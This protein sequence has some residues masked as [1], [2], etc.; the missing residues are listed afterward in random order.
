MTRHNNIVV[1][2]GTACGPKAAARARRCDPAARITIIEQ[3][4]N[5]SQATCGLP[6]Y[7]SGVIESRDDMV[8]RKP[9]YFRTVM[10]M[11]VLISTKATAVFPEAHKVQ[12]IDLKKDQTSDI[13]YDKLVL[14]TGAFPDIPKVEGASLNGIFT[15]SKIRDAL[16]IQ[17]LIAR[18]KIERV[19]V[20]GAGLIGLEMAEAF[21]SMG[22]KVTVIE[23][24]GWVLPKLLDFETAAYLEKHLRAKGVELLLGQR[25]TGFEDNG[26]ARVSGVV[27]QSKTIKTNLALMALGVRPN[28]ALARDAGLAIGQTGGISVNK[29]L[30]T[31]DRDIYAGGD[32]VENINL[33]TQQPILAPMGSTANKHGRV[34]GTNITGGRDT[35][36]G[37]LGTS[38]AKVFNC[39]VARVGFGER[40]ARQAGYDVITS[41]VPA[42][43]HANYYPG[44]REILVKL[45]ANRSGGKLLGGQVLG[46]GEAAK[47]IDA[48][49]SCLMLGATLENL[50]NVDLAYAPPYNSALDPLHNA[51]NVIW[52]KVSGYAKTLNP[53]EVKAKIDNGEEFILLDVR[54]AEEWE[55]SRIDAP[56]TRLIPLTELRARLDEL[57]RNKEIIIYCRTSI[58]AYQAQRILNGAGFDRV[59]FMDGS[60]RAWPFE[61]AEGTPDI[62]R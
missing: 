25:V 33:I 43:E 24:L 28:V 4:D 46:E 22:I 5:L 8:A 7:I 40:Q 44:A 51:A 55:T 52:N 54:S 62:S 21:I 26:E 15:L 9:D 48:L 50:A 47:R 42:Y 38:V 16:A 37:V 6:Y 45:I 53:M 30:Q 34:I 18:H 57:P 36:P 1:I 29:Y 35:F 13:E 60:L 49:A 3:D 17:D 61:V 2:G 14:A 10:N 32:C 20:I 27:T 39:N 31:S 59:R 12:V 19:A 56:Q 23:A 58:R 11:E 41:L